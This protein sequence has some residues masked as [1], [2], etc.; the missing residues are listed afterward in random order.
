MRS[1]EQIINLYSSNAGYSMAD[2]VIALLEHR[3]IMSTEELK[4]EISKYCRLE[5]VAEDITEAVEELH[6][7]HNS[8]IGRLLYHA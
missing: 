2:V 5:Q 7:T 3:A 4:T 6:I 8:K 1:I